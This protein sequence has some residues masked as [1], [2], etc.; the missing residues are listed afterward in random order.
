[1]MSAEGDDATSKFMVKLNWPIEVE[2]TYVCGLDGRIS[3]PSIK[4][5]VKESYSNVRCE[6]DD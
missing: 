1:M 4:A 6:R 2:R 3:V 5:P